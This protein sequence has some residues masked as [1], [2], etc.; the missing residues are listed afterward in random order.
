LPHSEIHGSKLVRSS[1]WLIAAYDVL[2]RLSA[3]R[4]PPNALS[5]LNHS[6]CRCPPRLFRNRNEIDS[7]KTS[8]SFFEV[9]SDRERLSSRIWVDKP[10]SS[11]SGRTAFGQTFSSRC[12]KTRDPRREDEVRIVV[13]MRTLL[14]WHGRLAALT[15]EVWW[16]QTGSNRRP[17][18]C[19]ARA[20]PTELWPRSLTRS[21]VGPGRV[22]LPTSRLS[23][24]RSN[25]LSYGP[26][27][28]PKPEDQESLAVAR[29][30]AARSRA[31]PI[32]SVFASAKKEKRRRRC[33][34]NLA[35]DWGLCVLR[36]PIA[37]RARRPLPLKD[38]P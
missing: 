3:P 1:S 13:S 14:A 21:M 17:H 31:A 7:R 26:P 4:H 24:V 36:N 25:H 35:P 18:A 20:L 34:A 15:N 30:E 27:F 37:A 6:H 22:E 28:E 23:G 12:Q 33:P 2:H 16:S 32:K 19:K 29:S 11:L 10:A 9:L 5:S 38:Y 8:F